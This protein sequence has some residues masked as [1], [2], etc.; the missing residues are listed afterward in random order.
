MPK[1]QDYIFALKAFGA[2]L[3]AL[4][5]AFAI[6]LPKPSWAMATA[7]IVAQPF[8]GMVMSKAIYRLG[9]TYVGAIFAMFALIAF[10]DS[11]AMQ[12]VALSLWVGLCVFLSG[13][14]KTPRAYAFVLAGYTAAIIA[15]PS[16]D[17]PQTIFDVA[18]ARCEEI[19]LG[20]LCATLVH[21]VVLPKRVGPVMADNLGRWFEDA[22]SWIDDLLIRIDD[23]PAQSADRRRLIVDAMALDRLRVHALFDSPLFKE[24]VSIFDHLREQM[25]LIA[26]YLVA[27]E[28]RLTI[29]RAERPDML[30][31]LAA[32]RANFT[33][34]F[35]A[36]TPENPRGAE[37]EE[38]RAMLKRAA[39]SADAMRHDPHGLLF[40]AL[41][42]RFDDLV[43]TW[44]RSLALRADFFAGRRSATRPQPQRLHVDPAMSA[45][46]GL[47]ASVVLIFICLF[48]MASGWPEGGL[49]AMM[50]AVACSLGASFD[51]PA[52]FVINFLIGTMIGIFV[53][54]FYL[55]GVLPHVTTFLGLVLVLAPFYIV[56]G[57]LMAMPAYLGFV[58][59]ILLGV[60]VNMGIENRMVFDF[61]PV[62]NGAV[63]QI[64]GLGVAAAALS[65][66]RASG[67]ESAIA[68][69]VTLIH[70]DLGR[71]VINDRA[72]TQENFL[73]VMHD[74][75]DGLMQRR[76]GDVARADI[77]I[78]G[79]LAALRLGHNIRLLHIEANELSPD[80]RTSLAHVLEV[81]RAHFDP[82]NEAKVM[83]FAGVIAAIEAAM[84]TVSLSP[85]DQASATLIVLGQM[86]HIMWQ[87]EEFFTYATSSR[88]RA[89]QRQF[90]ARAEGAAS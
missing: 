51:D 24:R 79:A 38:I 68:R 74:R 78:D 77:M 76:A 42:Q 52:G 9:G 27:V 72:M 33:A 19:S 86:R 14:D 67:T 57:A 81:M 41:L 49:A 31:P 8:A 13:L 55:F 23:K 61:L 36:A 58:F 29:L 65:V 54:C 37:A 7:L 15:F 39:P 17:V 20:I 69:I 53:A 62:I 83:S 85:S 45:M 63:A 12:V 40:A 11:P 66:T 71:L 64:I 84:A 56:A 32:I 43:L 90:W 16:V 4:Y 10:A 59:P 26:A 21:A 60:T 44:Q 89:A 50:V 47:T 48:W 73:S 3:L 75:I 87:N 18:L 46:S 5:I 88:L 28:D 80:M 35:Q 34:W 30:V 6:G 22:A 82:V 1:R 70:R 2:S 25:Q